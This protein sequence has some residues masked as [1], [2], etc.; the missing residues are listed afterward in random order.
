MPD[1]PSEPSADAPKFALG[2]DE[3]T[4]PRVARITHLIRNSLSNSPI[5]QSPEAWHALET[6]LPTLV[7]AII[8]EL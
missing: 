5:S 4:D 2:A 7:D 6:R 8:K 1:T 3:P